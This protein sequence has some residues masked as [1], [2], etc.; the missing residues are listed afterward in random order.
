MPD[1]YFTCQDCGCFWTVAGWAEFAAA[2]W[3]GFH[4]CGGAVVSTSA[5][6]DPSDP[7][8]FPPIS[9]ADALRWTSN[10]NPK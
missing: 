5:D 7:Y 2:G 4:Q 6:P 1:K 9:R 8:E 3:R 10:N